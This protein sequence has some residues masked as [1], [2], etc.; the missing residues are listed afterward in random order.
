MVIDRYDD[1]DRMVNQPQR[2]YF[3][4]G[5]RQLARLARGIIPLLFK[6]VLE[7]FV[8]TVEDI[9]YYKT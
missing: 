3:E 8:L 5:M 4:Y 6:T 9:T 2:T 1:G 7:R